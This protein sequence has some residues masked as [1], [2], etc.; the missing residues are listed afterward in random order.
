MPIALLCTACTFR[1][2]EGGGADSGPHNGGDGGP[3]IDGAEG[4]PYRKRITIDPARVSGAQAQFPVWIVLD[5]DAGLQE[6]A[7]Q[8]GFDIYF[9]AGDGTPI[10]YQIQRWTKAAGRLEAWVR[11]DLSDAADMVIELRY[12]DPSRASVANPAEVFASSFA[13]VWHLD[14]RLDTDAVADA[15]SK[16]P[17]SAG[18]L[19]PGDQVAAQLGGG[20]DFDGVDDRIL[21]TNP[22]IGGG[23]HTIS[24]WVNQRTTSDCDSIVTVGSPAGGDSRFL[25]SHLGGRLAAGFFTN[26][27]PTTGANPLPSIEDAGWVLLHWVFKG[28]NRQSRMYR[29]GVQVGSTYTFSGGIDTQGT[30]GNIGF[31]PAQWGTCWL[32]GILDEVRLATID[33]TAGWIATEHANQRSPQTFYTVGAEERAP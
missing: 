18:G 14:D 26:D 4:T 12:G 30:D 33:R 23:D 3:R 19:V 31:A 21:F 9:T 11:A 16:R 29:N 24:A 5:G 1:V 22:F 32:N 27:W 17:G 13:A 20:I 7:T 25:H 15:T 2:V 10:P 28:S 8:E 6:H